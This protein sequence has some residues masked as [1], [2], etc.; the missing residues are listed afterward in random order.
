METLRKVIETSI[1]QTIEQYV[2]KIVEKYKINKND[3]LLLWNS[4]LDKKVQKQTEGDSNE[5]RE[6]SNQGCIYKSSKGKNAGKQCGI[7]SKNG[8]KYC[9]VHKKYENKLE[10]EKKVLP[11]SKRNTSSSTSPESKHNVSSSKSKS[12]LPKQV[13]R[14][15]RKHKTLDKLYHQDTMLVFKSTAERVVIGKIINNNIVDLTSDDID[16][17]KKWGFQ[18]EQSIESDLESDSEDENVSKKVVKKAFGLS[19]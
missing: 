4:D 2:E 10:S 5:I 17:C 16:T 19:D 3:L 13:Q 6:D 8:G 14:I 1:N 7:K 15:L 9:S 12:P 18:Y 11:V